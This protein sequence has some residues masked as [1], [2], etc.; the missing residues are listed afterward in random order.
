MVGGVNTSET[1]DGDVL[2]VG[3]SASEPHAASEM[4]DKAAQA[5]TAKEDRRET[6][7]VVTLLPLRTVPLGSPATVAL[8][9]DLT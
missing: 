7:T 6:F 9:C 4:T 1:G 2:A 3:V 8:C 5:T